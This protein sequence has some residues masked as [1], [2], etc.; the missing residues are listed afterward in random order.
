VSNT[1]VVQAVEQA[2]LL[3]INTATADQ[4]KRPP[5]IGEA[6]SEKVIKGVETNKRPFWTKQSSFV[7]GED[8]F[9]VGR[10]PHAAT[11][12]EG[13]KQAFQNAKVEL[14][15]YA[16]VTDVEAKGVVIDTQMTFEEPPNPLGMIT[17]YQ[18]LRVPAK[19]LIEIQGQVQEQT[20]L[21]GQA[22]DQ[23]QRDLQLVQ[24]AVVKRYQRIEEQNRQ[25]QGT[26]DSV[27]RL[28]ESSRERVLRIEQAH[29]EVE[30]L[31]QQLS[32]KVRATELT[33]TPF[34]SPAMSNN[35]TKEK[36][37][38]EP[39]LRRIK[40]T[41]K[42]L[43]AQEAQLKDLSKRAKARLAKEDELARALEK[44]CKYL[45]RGMTREEVGQIM[46]EPA[47]QYLHIPS[48]TTSSKY[49]YMNK[50]G[51]TGIISIGFAF[52]ELV[53]S[54]DGCPGKSFHPATGI[55]P[56]PHTESHEVASGTIRSSEAAKLGRVL[57]GGTR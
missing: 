3:D 27:S 46:S 12:E 33:S 48:K 23:S 1:L 28:Q 11:V 25:I 17:V 8:L 38:A 9:V 10:A 40:D 13:R 42:K 15:N 41:E 52:N 51:A 14:M 22:L 18:L 6:V 56:A 50:S 39:L 36:S 43:D 7:E 24:Q 20:R 53:D 19:K 57:V 31:L 37:M 45:V 35:F 21:Q 49:R 5:G 29:T 30:Q 32:A 55:R 4:L 26:L 2:D 34:A 16:Q 47:E 44:K 54:L